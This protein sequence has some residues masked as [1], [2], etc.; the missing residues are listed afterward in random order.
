MGHNG[1]TTDTAASAR[2]VSNSDITLPHPNKLPKIM[3]EAPAV[4]D[5]EDDEDFDIDEADNT[6]I[7]V[8]AEEAV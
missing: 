6:K 1:N 3:N 5:D 2:A 7:Q 8:D 4:S